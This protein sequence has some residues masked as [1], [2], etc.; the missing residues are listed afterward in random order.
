MSIFLNVWQ[1]KKKVWRVWTQ[2]N[3]LCSAHVCLAV[4]T[5]VCILYVDHSYLLDKSILEYTRVDNRD[6]D[7]VSARKEP[8]A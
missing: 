7:T 4:V 5:I 8:V 2:H 3:L 1:I 6:V